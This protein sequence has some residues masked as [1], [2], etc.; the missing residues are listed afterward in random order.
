M[1]K[2]RN[3]Y[4]VAVSSSE[5][6]RLDDKSQGFIT[7][8]SVRLTIRQLQLVSVRRKG[9]FFGKRNFTMSFQEQLGE[10]GKRKITFSASLSASCLAMMEWPFY[11][12]GNEGYRHVYS[13]F[14][15]LPVLCIFPVSE[16]FPFVSK[17]HTQTIRAPNHRAEGSSGV[18]P[19]RV[20]GREGGQGR[21]G[22]GTKPSHV[23]FCCCFLNKAAI[24]LAQSD[25]CL[26]INLNINGW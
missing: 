23:S 4:T 5:L 16:E 18:L 2:A 11:V 7:V 19:R 13:T 17:F 14:D 26:T 20:G 8:P 15:Y 12:C 22:G 9:C 6:K 24:G 1:H 10:W 3:M 21:R 25:K